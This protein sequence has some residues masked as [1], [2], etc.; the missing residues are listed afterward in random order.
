[1][2]VLTPEQK[3]KLKA[4]FQQHR[5]SAGATGGTETT[6]GPGDAGDGSDLAPGAN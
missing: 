3:E 4:F 2:A 5:N 6:G 1:M